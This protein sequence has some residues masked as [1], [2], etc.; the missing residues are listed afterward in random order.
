[1][2]SEV[3]K[4]EFSSALDLLM[5]G[6][7]VARM[8]WNGKNMYLVYFSPVSNGLETLDIE[9]EVKPL[10]PFRVMKTVNDTYVPWLASQSDLL[11]NDWV[12][13]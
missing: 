7:K 6:S 4:M 12:E 10:Q 8:G 3:I 1:M 9:G 2:Q 11:A 13:L 5:C